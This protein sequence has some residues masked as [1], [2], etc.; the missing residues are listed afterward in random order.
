MVHRFFDWLGKYP[1]EKPD[2]WWRR[3]GWA[4]QTRSYWIVV[5]GCIALYAGGMILIVVLN[6]VGEVS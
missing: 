2:R 1:E 4:G 3:P 5:L 6:G